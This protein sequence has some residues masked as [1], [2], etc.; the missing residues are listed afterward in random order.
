MFNLGVTGS[1]GTQTTRREIVILS[2]LLMCTLRVKVSI[3]FFVVQF[4][5]L[6]GKIG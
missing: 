2:T 4:E 3:P 5:Y 1:L 6:A